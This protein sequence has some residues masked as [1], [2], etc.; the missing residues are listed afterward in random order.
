MRNSI[1]EIPLIDPFAALAK[2]RSLSS[3]VNPKSDKRLLSSLLDSAPSL[4]RSR[5][6]TK[7]EGGDADG[8]GGESPR[9]EVVVHGA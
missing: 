1:S 6:Q 4:F 5:L 8:D 3:L 7:G 9:G 2:M